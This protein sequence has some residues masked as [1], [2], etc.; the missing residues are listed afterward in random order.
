MIVF[1]TWVVLY[2][3]KIHSPLLNLYLLPIIASALIFGKL[4]TVVEVAAI[5][6]CFMFFAY[7]PASQDPAVAALLGR[8]SS[9]CP[10]R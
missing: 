10:R 8:D 1:I 4:M 3:G 9:P 7:D 5:I 6:G 2:T